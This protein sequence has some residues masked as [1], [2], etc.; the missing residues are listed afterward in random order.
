[1]D[2]QTVATD[3]FQVKSSGLN[4]PSEETREREQ[5]RDLYFS[6]ND[7]KILQ[8]SQLDDLQRHLELPENATDEEIIEAA[9]ADIENFRQTSKFPALLDGIQAS[10]DLSTPRY[11]GA[12]LTQALMLKYEDALESQS[13]WQE[14][15]DTLQ[16]VTKYPEAVRLGFED[17]KAELGQANHTEPEISSLPNKP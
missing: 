8:R 1:M 5:A 14:H 10:D 7:A 6:L 9:R 13:F 16:Q 15:I 2:E 11:G 17:A 3:Q 4:S 12:L